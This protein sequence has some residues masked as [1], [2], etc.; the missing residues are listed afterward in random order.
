MTAV[1][2]AGYNSPDLL[3]AENDDTIPVD[4]TTN[5]QTEQATG[6]LPHYFAMQK[7]NY[8]NSGVPECT[9]TIK[10]YKNK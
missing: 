6:M 4:D 2:A 7:I 1:V 8:F 9:S 10:L 5:M 3:P